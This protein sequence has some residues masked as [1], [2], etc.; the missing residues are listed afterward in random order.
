MRLRLQGLHVGI[1]HEQHPRIRQRLRISHILQVHD[2][3]RHAALHERHGQAVEVGQ[4]GVVVSHDRPGGALEHQRV[5]HQHANAFRPGH[6]VVRERH[7]VQRIDH[8]LHLGGVK[9]R[10]ALFPVAGGAH[11]VQSLVNTVRP[12]H[13][14]VIIVR[15]IEQLGGKRGLVV[16]L[17]IRPVARPVLDRVGQE[18]HLPPRGRGHRLHAAILQESGLEHPLAGHP[19]EIVRL[20][21]GAGPHLRDIPVHAIQR[22]QA[23]LRAHDLPLGVVHQRVGRHV[24]AHVHPLALPVGLRI[25]KT[26]VQ[27]PVIQ[28]VFQ[29]VR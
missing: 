25:G 12:G 6:L 21:R 7:I 29:L 20:A 27:S 23:G 19:V 1:R 16:P 9:T 17:V 13:H 18:E 10:D 14:L 2:T 22:R 15:R 28:V 4:L 3:N 24:A 11:A 5:G 26:F 8:H